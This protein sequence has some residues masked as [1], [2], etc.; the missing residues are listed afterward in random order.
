MQQEAAVFHDLVVL[1]L[2]Q[3]VTGPY[4]TMQL[5]DFG[6]RVI[7]VEPLEGDWAR[8]MGPPFV[9]TESALFLSMNR[10]KQSLALNYTTPEG[11]DILRQ[12]V[13]RADVLVIDMAPA[14]RRAYQLTYDALGALNRRLIYCAITPFGEQGPL[15]D[16]PAAE[17]VLQAISGYTR[18]VGQPGGEPVRLGADIAGINSAL[19]V[20][21][22]IVAALIARQHSGVGQEV[23]VSQLG[24]LLATKTIMIA[25]QGN[26]DD[27]DGFHLAG[28]TDGPEQGWQ[29]SDRPITF[30]F[31]TSPDGWQRFCRDL[32]LE[33]LLDD[34]RFVDWYRT[35]CLGAEAQALRSEYERG[36]IGQSA[37]AL[38]TL[39]RALGGNA[40]PYLHYD[41][42]LDT[43][44]V[45]SLDILKDVPQP[46]GG[47]LRLIGCP[48]QCSDSQPQFQAMPPRLGEH[49]GVILQDIG[50][51]AGHLK[52][53]Q[54][55]Q[56]V[57]VS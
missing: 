8:A 17:L 36:F 57:L 50:V 10:H 49:T 48:W 18:Y 4:A 39:I 35:M 25:A 24:A 33:Y 47:A 3:G 9:G 52:M 14:A 56:I 27:W 38:I 12:L 44:P 42:L 22:G 2:A 5:A 32:A 31:G 46:A 7:K 30:D 34:P 53:L 23:Q 21:Q 1:E 6:A 29:T 40:F 20:Y 19:F 51:A 11:L 55:R 13:S 26:P 16:Q 54:E 15:C 41:E 37:E 43:A 28:T 45:H